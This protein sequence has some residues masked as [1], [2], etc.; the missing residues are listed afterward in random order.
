MGKLQ[1]KKKK[2]HRQTGRTSQSSN[3]GP[4]YLWSLADISKAKKEQHLETLECVSG[5]P[6]SRRGFG[7]L[8]N[9][10]PFMY[11]IEFW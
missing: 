8:Y 3:L 2:G 7:R 6:R 10:L 11:K 5:L 1:K 9:L 4:M